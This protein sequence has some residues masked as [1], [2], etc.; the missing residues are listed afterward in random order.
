MTKSRTSGAGDRSPASA[1]PITRVGIVGAG[2]MGRL[3]ARTISQVA[4]SDGN[5]VL[6]RVV[7]HHP[8]RAEAAA[9]QFHC[10]ASTDLAT[11]VPEVD[12]VVVCVPTVDHGSVTELMLECDRD[13]LVEKPLAATVAEGQYLADLACNRGRILQVGHLEWYNQAWRDAIDVAGQPSS[14]EVERLNPVS[15][16]GLDIDVVQDFMLHDLDWVTR[17]LRD[18]IVDL[19]ARGS[20]VVHDQLDEAEVELRF[21]SGCRVKL[22]ASRVAGERRRIVRVSGSKGSATGDLLTRRLMGASEASESGLDPLVRQWRAFL[23]S[24]R[25]RTSPEADGAVGVA[26]LTIVERIRKAIELESKHARSSSRED[27]SALGG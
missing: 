19:T 22:R 4:A 17:L 24:V 20:C 6:C 1:V 8:G 25:H 27:G 12:A 7:D 3:H 16:R 10:R 15:D 13:V 5:C 11:L 26:A 2:P 18:E 21:R 14:I 9:E 23:E